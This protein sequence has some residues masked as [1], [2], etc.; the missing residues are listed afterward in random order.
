MV[1]HGYENDTFPVSAATGETVT[2][3]R[4]GQEG[5]QMLHASINIDGYEFGKVITRLFEDRKASISGVN[6]A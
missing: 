3:S 2:V 5:G 4:P 6:V 1:P